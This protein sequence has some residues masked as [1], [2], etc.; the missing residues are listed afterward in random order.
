M[1]FK[2]SKLISVK[3]LHGKYQSVRQVKLVTN[4]QYRI[5]VTPAKQTLK[6]YVCPD[7]CF[8]KVLI[9]YAVST[10]G[11]NIIVLVRQQSVI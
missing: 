10:S 4:S 6:N 5:V 8:V 11:E 2:L 9:R 1:V 7:I 3:Q